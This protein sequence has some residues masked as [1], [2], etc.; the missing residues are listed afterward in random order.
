MWD[1]CK[2]LWSLFLGLFRSR[3]SLEAENFAL[4]QQIIVF[5][6][7]FADIV[8]LPSGNGSGND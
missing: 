8:F 4:R 1:A 6:T 3:T 2:V 5:V 7:F